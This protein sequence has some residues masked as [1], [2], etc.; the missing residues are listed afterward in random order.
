MKLQKKSV[1]KCY[2]KN[3]NK[4]YGTAKIL[5]VVGFLGQTLRARRARVLLFLYCLFDERSFLFCAYV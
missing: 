3:N 2:Q 1:E 5:A 4:E